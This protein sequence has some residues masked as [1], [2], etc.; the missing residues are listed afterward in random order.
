MINFVADFCERTLFL[1][2]AVLILRT[3][4]Y[5]FILLFQD[6]SDQVI[7]PPIIRSQDQYRHLPSGS[8]STCNHSSIILALCCISHAIAFLKQC[9]QWT[10]CADDS[11]STISATSD[12]GRLQSTCW[13]E[14]IGRHI[15][16]ISSCCSSDE[17]R[18]FV[19]WQ[20]NN[21]IFSACT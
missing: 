9:S 19:R 16:Q 2:T 8:T 5:L 6:I 17:D 13:N 21:Y 14:A 1:F 18:S 20:W 15:H 11:R 3:I 10:L 7:R 12:V 4:N